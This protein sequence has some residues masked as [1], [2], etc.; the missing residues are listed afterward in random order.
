M[1]HHYPP[2]S[3]QQVPSHGPSGP[4]RPV[5]SVAVVVLAL[6]AAGAIVFL[7]GA[8]DRA[9]ERET[10]VT[11]EVALLIDCTRD[12]ATGRPVA[13]VEV[14]NPTDLVRR[15]IVGVDFLDGSGERQTVSL[16]ET[17]PISP[18]LKV[19]LAMYGF[20]EVPADSALECR[21]SGASPMRGSGES[22]GPTPLGIAR[23]HAST[24]AG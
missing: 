19:S 17:E 4:K 22:T 13:E 10:K 2:R 1:S 12:E 18:G 24:H 7:A 5:S 14:R 3:P 23:P 9:E 15:F 8:S 20:G 16:A 6:A 21:I 11:E